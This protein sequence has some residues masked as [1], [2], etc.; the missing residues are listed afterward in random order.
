[1]GYALPDFI[2]E[3]VNE[4]IDELGQI[5]YSWSVVGWLGIAEMGDCIPQGEHDI[6]QILKWR[7]GTWI[8]W[9]YALQKG[10]GH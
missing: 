9:S 4:E 1:M 6:T 5:R 2:L 10:G 3:R 8:K 7:R